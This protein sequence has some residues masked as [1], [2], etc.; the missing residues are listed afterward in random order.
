[1]GRTSYEA[2]GDIDS[3]SIKSYIVAARDLQYPE[4][5]IKKLE[6][7]KNDIE[8]TRIMTTARKQQIKEEKGWHYGR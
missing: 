4:S 3:W 1:M 5:V 7:A 2:S 6:K 8:A